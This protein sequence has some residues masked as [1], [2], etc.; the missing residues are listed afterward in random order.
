MKSI[1]QELRRYAYDLVIFYQ[2]NNQIDINEI[3]NDDLDKLCSL[4]INNDMTFGNEILG[5]D[6]D[7]FDSNIL[8]ALINYLKNS[9]DKCNETLFLDNVKSGIRSYLHHNMI[10]LLD[11]A[12]EDFIYNSQIEAA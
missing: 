8:P 2:K 4:I 11:H 12:L 3:P 6:N 7:S 10:I 1:N 5:S 9:S